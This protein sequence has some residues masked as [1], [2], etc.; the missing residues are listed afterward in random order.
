MRIWCC[1]SDKKYFRVIAGVWGGDVQ[2]FLYDKEGLDA[3]LKKQGAYFD[4]KDDY[5][6]GDLKWAN[7]M[8]VSWLNGELQKPN[9]ES[10]K[11]R[12]ICWTDNIDVSD[13]R[14]AT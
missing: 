1:E 7:E 13:W 4:N 14:G 8:V 11:M 12:F 9:C 10:C 6:S 5:P 2:L 3:T